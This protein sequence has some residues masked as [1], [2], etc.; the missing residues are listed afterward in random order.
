M[1]FWDLEAGMVCSSAEVGR[2]IYSQVCASG[3]LIGLGSERSIV[4]VAQWWYNR[5]LG[6]ER[7]E[8]VLSGLTW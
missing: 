8:Y 7:V 6:G 2:V 1:A 4:G 3:S 5:S